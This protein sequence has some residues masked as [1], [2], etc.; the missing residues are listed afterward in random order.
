MATALA[1]KHPSLVRRLG[2]SEYPLPGFGYEES[3]NPAPFWDLYQNWQLAFFQVPDLAEF[4]MSGKERQFLQWYFFHGSYSGPAAFSEDTVNRYATS[5]SKPGFLRAMLGPFSSATV[6]ADASFFKGGF[7]G[8]GALSMPVL[9]MGGEAS[10]GLEP[11]LKQS[12]EPIAS[13]LELDIIPKAG[14]WIADE[15]PEWVAN[16]VLEFLAE[17]DSPLPAVD[18]SYL[19]DLVTLKVGYFGTLRNA[20]MGGLRIS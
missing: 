17:D 20:A 15:N 4:L 18:L 9:A 12:F 1:A 19:R 11:V 6:A 8:E 5:I 7:A 14:H 2:L 13:D 3:S 16:R 10:L